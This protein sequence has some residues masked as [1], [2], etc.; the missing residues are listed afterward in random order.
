MVLS[1]FWGR[2][3]DLSRGWSI[4][5]AKGELAVGEDLELPKST[6]SDMNPLF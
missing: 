5:A 1:S 2:R 4:T 3:V 6:T